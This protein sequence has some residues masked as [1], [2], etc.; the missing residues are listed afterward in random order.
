MKKKKREIVVVWGLV[1]KQHQLA[2]AL[3]NTYK[4]E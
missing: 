1:K 3:I 4:W 2:P